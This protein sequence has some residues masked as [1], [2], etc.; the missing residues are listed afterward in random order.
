MDFIYRSR[1]W[2]LTGALFVLR[3]WPKNKALTDVV[4]DTAT[5]HVQIHGLPLVYLHEG[6]AKGIGNL[7]GKLHLDSVRRCAVG[8]RYIRFKTDIAIYASISAGFF[9]KREDGEDS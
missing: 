6:T 3:D 7:M 2:S 9:Q 4:F 1:L 5:F 8:Q